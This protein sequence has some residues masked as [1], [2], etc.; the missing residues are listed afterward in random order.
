V[1][2]SF[3]FR[4]TLWWV[5]ALAVL[6]VLFSLGVYSMLAGSARERFDA[7]LRAAGEV[8]ALS[9]NHEIEEHHGRTE[10]E[11]AIGLVLQTMH[12]VSFPRQSIV[13][14]EGLRQVA[15]KPG[16]EG[17]ETVAP[18][19][20]TGFH[21]DGA[22]RI[23]VFETAVPA[24]R[25]KYTIVVN[26]SLR[27]LEEELAGFRRVL[28]WCV[29]MG[30]LFASIGGYF[31]ARRNLAPIV[32]MTDEVNRIT[33]ENLHQ[34]LAVANAKDELGRLAGTFNEL[35]ERLNASFDDQRRFMA[36]ASHE[37]RTPLSV[38]LTAAQVNLDGGPRTT[39]EYQEALRIVTE[40]LRRL[41]R[42]VQEM[43]L[44]A[45]GDAGA[46][47]PTVSSFYLDELIQEAVRAARIIGDPLGVRVVVEGL[48]EAPISGDEGLI[49]QML[50]GL[51]DNAIRHTPAGGRVTVELVREEG[52]W[53]VEVADTGTGIPAEDQPYIFDRFYR[54]NK[55]RTRAAGGAGLGLSIARWIAT[56]HKGTLGLTASGAEG[57]VF[58]VRLPGVGGEEAKPR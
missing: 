39:A 32:A 57:T 40:Q 56:L 35:L 49:R 55:A 54:A 13:V 27:T 24:L 48:E 26:Q 47:A 28:Y 21:S 33:S 18:G 43:F 51:L 2:N 53:R 22:Y 8:T 41:K 36:D 5:G 1:T 3:R 44:L 6:L 16:I 46:F 34:R 50:L 14:F 19:L 42:I 9:V 45:Q 31:L 7:T 37:L 11:A 15:A 12:R 25:T 10:G 17:R 23:A 58:T 20:A 52:T 29:P 4:L 30:I 38:A